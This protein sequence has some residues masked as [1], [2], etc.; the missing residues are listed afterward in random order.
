MRPRI[1]D[2]RKA[3]DSFGKLLEFGSSLARAVGEPLLAITDQAI[4]FSVRGR[5]PVLRVLFDVGGVALF[6]SVQIVGMSLVRRITANLVKVPGP[7]LLRLAIGTS[8][9]CLVMEM[10]R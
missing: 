3:A 6:K 8:G 7:Y 1:A 9:M 2:R 5:S 10:L 4:S